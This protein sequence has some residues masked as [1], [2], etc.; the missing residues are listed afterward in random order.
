[1]SIKEV[2]PTNEKYRQGYYRLKNVSK[3]IGDPTK[4]IFRSSWEYNFCKYCDE[5]ERI[6]KWSSEPV[7]IPYINPI[8]NKEHKYYVDF[9]LRVIDDNGNQ[10]DFFAEI[11][12]S[13]QLKKPILKGKKTFKKIKHY[14]QAAK[15]WII[16]VAKFKAAEAFCKNRGGKFILVTEKFLFR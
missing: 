14:N 12:P 11:K 8:D 10:N 1:M 13:A 3:Y 5:N 6:I 7:A 2:K 16:N 9:Y 15:S 4:I